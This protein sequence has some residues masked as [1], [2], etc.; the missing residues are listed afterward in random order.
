MSRLP[1]FYVEGCPLHVIQRGNNRLPIFGDAEDFLFYR[2]C[3]SFSARK[4]KVAVH[5]YV[6]MTNHVH[7]L[8][9]P[10]SS[11]AVPKMMQSIGRVYVAYFNKRYART[12][13]LWE[14]RYK[15]AIVEGDLYFLTCMRYIEQNP[16]RAGM[17]P[18]AA[19]YQWSSHSANAAGAPDDVISRHPLYLELGSREVERQQAYGAMFEHPVDQ[20][21]LSR[22]R[23]ATQ[24]AWALGA[25]AFCADVQRQG[26]RAKRIPLGR[27]IKE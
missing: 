17:V 4:H 27:P 14:G 25:P 22:I 15:A 12:G 1:R 2:T 23:D 8:V 11:V 21:D 20:V 13:T 10:R 6:L 5:A 24:N 16:V 26:R 7:A 3:L 19:A 18:N 9:S